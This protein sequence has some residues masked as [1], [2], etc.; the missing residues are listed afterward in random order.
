M[1]RELKDLCTQTVLLYTL[2]STDEYGQDTWGD[3]VEAKCHIDGR[4]REVITAKG[5][6]KAASGCAYLAEIYPWLTEAT[7]MYVP[8]LASTLTG[9][10][11]GYRWVEIVG[12]D[13]LYDE[14]G[15]Y[16]QVVYYGE[17]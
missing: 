9:E 6:K 14:D 5:S 15:V 10:K 2:Q 17:N 7:N 1:D 16:A 3:K 4:T 12:V 13:V 8:D 11:A